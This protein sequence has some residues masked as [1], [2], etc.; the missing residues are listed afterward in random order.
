MTLTLQ[1]CDDAQF[2]DMFCS[3]HCVLRLRSTQSIRCLSNLQQSNA[4]FFDSDAVAGADSAG[5]GKST[6]GAKTASSVALGQVASVA[7]DPHSAKQCAVTHGDCLQLVDTREMEVTGSRRQAHDGNI[8]YISTQRLIEMKWVDTHTIAALI[9]H[10]ML[11]LTAY[12]RYIHLPLC[13]YCSIDAS[14]NLL[15]SYRSLNA[16]IIEQ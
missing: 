2:D 11:L 10:M 13:R 3:P 16:I 1:P 5:S 7:W 6:G 15:C 9:P 12:C 8:R 14:H 4:L